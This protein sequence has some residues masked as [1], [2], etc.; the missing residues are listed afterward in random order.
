MRKGSKLLKTVFICTL[1]TGVLLVFS[2][3]G[4]Q[5]DN[6]Q[7]QKPTA[8]NNPALPE[9]TDAKTEADITEGAAQKEYEA[10]NK[11]Y[12]VAEPNSEDAPEISTLTF[13]YNGHTLTYPFS[14]KDMEDIGITFYDYIKDRTVSRRGAV[15]NI[16][17]MTAPGEGKMVLVATNLS[18]EPLDI[19]D[20]TVTYIYSTNTKYAVNS[21]QPGTTTYEEVLALFGRDK[22]E[23]KNTLHNENIRNEDELNLD[24]QLNYSAVFDEEGVVG[25]TYVDLTI[26]MNTDIESHQISDSVYSVLFERQ[27]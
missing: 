14:L 3:C 18:S 8:N 12:E 2:A 25:D 24:M 6:T 11:I 26:I 5:S 21:V 22:E 1:M 16:D 27:R 9:K 17:G 13:T 19:M 7:S 4:K 20:C 15:G 10:E 23:R